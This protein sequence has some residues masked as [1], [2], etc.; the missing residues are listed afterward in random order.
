[1]RGEEAEPEREQTAGEIRV[2]GRDSGRGL[3]RTEYKDA[4]NR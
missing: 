1:M 4:E 2:S 3:I